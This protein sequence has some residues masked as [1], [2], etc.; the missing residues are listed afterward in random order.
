[1]SIFNF[2][3]KQLRRPT[4]SSSETHVP[5]ISVSESIKRFI[6]L[7]DRLSDAS[8]DFIQIVFRITQMQGTRKEFQQLDFGSVHDA[9]RIIGFMEASLN[10]IELQILDTIQ[11]EFRYREEILEQESLFM[12]LTTLALTDDQKSELLA[13]EQIHK[14]DYLSRATTF[15]EQNILNGLESKKH[16]LLSEHDIH[17]QKLQKVEDTNE[18]AQRQNARFKEMGQ[19]TQKQHYHHKIQQYPELSSSYMSELQLALDSIKNLRNGEGTHDDLSSLEI[20]KEPVNT[21]K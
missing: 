19:S 6:N 3:S 2:L 9:Y 1:M 15:R 17:A 10:L 14:D 21:S 8:N 4:G 16:I 13:F 11:F 7:I 12:E 18:M 5:K 20:D